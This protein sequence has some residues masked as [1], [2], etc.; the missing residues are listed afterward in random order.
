MSDVIFNGSANRQPLGQASVELIFDNEHGRIN[1]GQYGQYQELSLKRVLG[2]DQQSSYF[3]NGVRCRRRDVIDLLRGTGLGPRNYAIVEQ[4][5]ISR[6][7]E[8]K[9]DELRV[10]IE[11]VAGTAQY[12]DRRRQTEN[13][14]RATREN[15]ERMLD[16]QQE[17]AKQLRHLKKQANAAERYKA[18]KEHLRAMKAEHEVLAWRKH[19]QEHARLKAQLVEQETAM[20]KVEAAMAN[21]EHQETALTQER[22][23]SSDHLQQ[24]QKSFYALG[25]ELAQYEE[26]LKSM[27]L[28]KQTVRSQLDELKNQYEHQDNQL[29][30]HRAQHADIE[31]T[32]SELE[33]SVQGAKLDFNHATDQLTTQENA[34]ASWQEDW[35]KFTE[36]SS[37][38]QQTITAMASQ[39]DDL[40]RQQANLQQQTQQAEQSLPHCDST[41][42][43]NEMATLQQQSDAKDQ[44]LCKV[45]ADIEA[46]QNQRQALKQQQQLKQQ[47]LSELQ[48]QRAADVAKLASLE[49]LQQAA[50]GQ[51]DHDNKTWLAQQG[52]QDYKRVMDQLDVDPKWERAV[53]TVLGPHLEAICADQDLH[54]MAKSIADWSGKNVVIHASCA[55]SDQEVSSDSLQ[56]KVKHSAWAFH[57][58]AS[59]Y[60]AETL[61]QAFAR[62]KTLKAHESVVLA[63]G[64]WLG[65]GWLKMHASTHQHHGVLERKRGIAKLQA[66]VATASANIDALQAECAQLV[67]DIEAIEQRSIQQREHQR[68]LQA[69]LSEVRAAHAGI[70]VQSEQKK[71]E[72]IRL[73]KQIENARV[74]CEDLQARADACQKAQHEAI[75]N[76]QSYATSKQAWESKR[77]A[78]QDV[79]QQARSAHQQKKEQ[80][81]QLQIR[82][83]SLLS[84]RDYLQKQISQEAQVCARTSDKL[85]KLASDLDHA[86]EPMEALKQS[87][88]GVAQQHAQQQ[89]SMA[90]IQATLGESEHKL[91]QCIQQKR[92]FEEA[93]AQSRNRAESHRLALQ[94]TI[95]H[96]DTHQNNIKASG[97]ELDAMHQA[98]PE[99]ASMDAWSDKISSKEKNIDRL[100]PINLAAIDEYAQVSERKSYLDEQQV[101][102]ESALGMLESA[103]AKIDQE[104]KAMFKATYDKV[105]TCFQRL[106][107]QIFSGGKATLEMTENNF[108]QAGIVVKAQPP[109]KRNHFIHLLSGGEKALTAIALVFALFEANPAPFCVLDEVDAPLDEVNVGRFCR[110]V[111]EMAKSVQFVVITHNKATMQHMDQLNGVTMREPGVTRMVSVDIT[112]AVE[113]VE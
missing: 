51:D 99:D 36:S 8:A 33:A 43:D 49:A 17:L 65:P 89:Q 78:I 60:V 54:A 41:E 27:Q 13:R 23:A 3:I 44:A 19:H 24:H 75:S 21:A 70:S 45:L 92:S 110:V 82:Y 31:S 94:T 69:S 72:H 29:V 34:L 93:M 52:W 42:L 86:D 107:P 84:E 90:E 98:L 30:G 16:I 76:Q 62:I 97:F 11:E 50:K 22:Q 40:R 20:A 81:D 112:E 95:V 79:L 26:K 56:N 2:R 39:L 58:L 77:E 108:L 83:Q 96:R 73:T 103:I 57:L 66:T 68:Q 111:E 53:E 61:D 6:I 63:N 113:L 10:Y 7:I 18:L 12:K 48:E 15:L 71:S 59:V 101:D 35:L 14:I 28:Q 38:S 55:Q 109:G 4:G 80:F 1:Q 5:T 64:L 67:A 85:K 100:G 87:I 32:L 88:Q 74:Q 46:A 91:Q 37:S 9:P 104:T 106:F 102:L 105:N 47:Q 25:S